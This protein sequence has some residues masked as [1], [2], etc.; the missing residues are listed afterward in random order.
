MPIAAQRLSF[1]VPESFDGPSRRELGALARYR[2]VRLEHELGQGG[3]WV[4]ELTRTADGFACRVT[5][6][7]GEGD[8]EGQRAVYALDDAVSQLEMRVRLALGE[9]ARRRAL[10]G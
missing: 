9:P 2:I 8:G 1:R 10:A 7:D 4:V 6:D 5:C 3:A